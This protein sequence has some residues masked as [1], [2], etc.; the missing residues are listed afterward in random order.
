M[1]TETLE[2]ANFLRKEIISLEQSLQQIAKLKK[3]EPEGIVY[4]EITGLGNSRLTFK[5]SAYN[6]VPAMYE[7]KIDEGIQRHIDGIHDRIETLLEKRLQRAQRELD[8]L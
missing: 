3:M 4:K 6:H 7:E 5:T 8:E 1:K 2:K